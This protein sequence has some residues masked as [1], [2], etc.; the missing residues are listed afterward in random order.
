MNKDAPRELVHD[1]GKEIPV[2]IASIPASV[3]QRGFA[4]GIVIFFSVAF[5]LV[6]YRSRPDRYDVLTL[7]FRLFNPSFA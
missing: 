3:Q 4:L 6:P 2:L 1:E 5:A 7:S